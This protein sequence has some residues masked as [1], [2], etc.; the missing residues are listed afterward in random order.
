[1][2][3]RARERSGF[4]PETLDRAVHSTVKPCS[5]TGKMQVGNLKFP[6]R[7][8]QLNDVVVS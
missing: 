8:R 7:V 4:P 5:A 3:A 1:M 2:I 6:I